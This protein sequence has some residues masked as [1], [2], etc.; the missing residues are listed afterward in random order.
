MNRNKEFSHTLHAL[1]RLKRQGKRD[2][3][4]YND[5]LRRAQDLNPNP[6]TPIGFY[7]DKE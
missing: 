6:N 3:K 4:L 1:M 7:L 2:S 5:M